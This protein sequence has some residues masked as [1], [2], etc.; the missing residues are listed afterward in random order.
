[1]TQ[2]PMEL[3]QAWIALLGGGLAVLALLVAAQLVLSLRQARQI[4]DLAVR[5][6]PAG[7]TPEQG[8]LTA[9]KA[10]EGAESEMEETLESLS[11]ARDRANRAD[12]A[13]QAKSTFL[14]MMS[15]ELRTPLSAIIG[16][17]EMIE[18][19]AMGPIGNE[20]YCHY[21][22][23]IRESGRHVLD[24]VN[25][26]LDLSK[27]ESGRETLREQD[28]PADLLFDGVRMI[29]EGLAEEAGV[30]LTFDYPES[31]PAIR[32]DKRRLTQVLVNLLSNAVKFTPRDGRVSLRCWA[33]EGSGIVFQAIDN[34][35]GI[36]RADI[37]LAL[38]V[39]GQ[40]EN[41]CKPQGTGLGLPLAK[42]L[43]ELHGGTLDLQSEL[44]EGT[45]VTLRLPA[46]RIVAQPATQA[47]SETSEEEA[48]PQAAAG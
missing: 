41:D 43:V 12:R 32:A 5:Q 39:F 15:H 2:L 21:A 13:N 36:A 20:K 44:D 14:T 19:Q 35:V 1:M 48:L 31:L 47:P 26:I 24:I 23:D 3:P 18:Q 34:G 4:R 7:D 46:Y 22:T 27:V 37:P 29:V 11:Q 42:A 45:T 30:T 38:S 40:V 16:F 8:V 10:V 25:D 6:T 9:Q 17:A 33:T 28:I